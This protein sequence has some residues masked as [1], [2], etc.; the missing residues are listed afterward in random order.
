P[1]FLRSGKTPDLGTQ[2]IL[3]HLAGRRKGQIWGLLPVLT[4]WDIVKLPGT[5]RI[6]QL[7]DMP[8]R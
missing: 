3:R 8:Y 4:M 1:T 6:Y 7:N 2:T 5:A